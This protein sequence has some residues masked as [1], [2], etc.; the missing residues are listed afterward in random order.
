MSAC[1]ITN[2]LHFK[3]SKNLP[4]LE[5][6]YSAVYIVIDVDCDSGRLF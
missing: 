1:V 5:T 2:I 4:N 3:H 6:N